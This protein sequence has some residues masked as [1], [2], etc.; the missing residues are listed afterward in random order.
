[1][2]KKRTN[3]FLITI[4]TILVLGSGYLYISEEIRSGSLFGVAQ[5]SSLASTTEDGT[6]SD[7]TA[8][9][10]TNSK[11]TSDISFLS[12]LVSLKKI[13]IDQ[14]IFANNLFTRLK[15]NSVSIGTSIPGRP[16]PFA[17]ID[18]SKITQ[19]TTTPRVVTN[20]ATQITATSAILNGVVSS[21]N[22]VTDTYFEYGTT[23]TLGQSTNMVKQQSLVGTFIKNILDLSS[24]TTY[25]F[26]ACAKINGASVCGNIV[27]FT[28]N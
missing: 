3:K 16:N 26:K 15:S 19:T 6:T 1:M 28:T 21:A 2:K 17:P 12:T 18:E 7:T 27:S 23:E 20:Q 5:G 22:G 11:I 8:T 25:F 13:K 9:T 24:K 4:F 10:S 14:T